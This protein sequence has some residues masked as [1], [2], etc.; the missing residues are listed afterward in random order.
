MPIIVGPTGVEQIGYSNTYPGALAEHM[1]LQ[2]LLLLPVPDA[3]DTDLAALTEPLA[4]GEHAVGLA[5]L[6]RGPAL[7]RRRAAA[8]SGWR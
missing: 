4:V 7:P 5:G 3:L 2:E 1:V 8:R 6:S